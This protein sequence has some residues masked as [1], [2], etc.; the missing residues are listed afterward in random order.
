MNEMVIISNSI[1]KGSLAG[2]KRIEK[3]ACSLSASGIK[4]SVICPA[5]NVFSNPPGIKVIGISNRL[6]NWLDKDRFGF[7]TNWFGLR[8]RGIIRFLCPVDYGIFLVPQMIIRVQSLGLKK[9]DAIFTSALPFSLHLVG[10]FCSRGRHIWLA[11]NRDLWANSVYRAK[12]PVFSSIALVVEK[13]VLSSADRK[14][15]VSRAICEVLKKYGTGPTMLIENLPMRMPEIR[16]VSVAENEKISVLYAGSSYGGKRDLVRCKEMLDEIMG[17]NEVVAFGLDSISAERFSRC[18]SASF[19]IRE[20]VSFNDLIKLA[21]G[22]HYGLVVLA[23]QD[24]DRGVLT[25]KV[26]DYLEMGL[27]II[28]FGPEGS[29]LEVLI[30]EYM[31]GFYFSYSAAYDNNNAARCF[32]GGVVSL[33]SFQEKCRIL[34]G[35]ME[36]S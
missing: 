32:T 11:D 22:F 29:E 7:K 30:E 2:G 4:V 20:G 27:P 17:L 25:S 1:G 31:I 33:P 5:S 10:Y 36:N 9:R 3:L 15:G 28:A 13:V 26:F 24:F 23:D 14:I 35:D 12:I 6:F 8:F 18:C 16:R 21:G 19:Q 34:I